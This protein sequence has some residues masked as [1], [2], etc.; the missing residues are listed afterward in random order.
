MVIHV[1]RLFGSRFLR[2]R[3]DH[4]RRATTLLALRL[5]PKMEDEQL[6]NFSLRYVFIDHNDGEYLMEMS[7]ITEA[8]ECETMHSLKAELC[9]V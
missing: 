1:L 9:S 5:A 3:D 8:V 4:C 2:L 6:R 7:L